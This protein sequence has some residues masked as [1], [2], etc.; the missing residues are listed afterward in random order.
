MLASGFAT[1]DSELPRQFWARARRRPAGRYAFPQRCLRAH[2]HPP[3]HSGRTAEGRETGEQAGRGTI[4][5][6]LEEEYTLW[7]VQTGRKLETL[8]PK[9]ETGNPL[10]HGDLEHSLA[11]SPDESFVASACKRGGYVVEHHGTPARGFGRSGQ[12]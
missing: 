9:R 11:F 6:R 5:M 7:D 10:P 3:K 12:R 4:K 2:G 8:K 1:C